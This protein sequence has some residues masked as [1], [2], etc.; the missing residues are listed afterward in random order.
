MCRSFTI[1]E[2]FGTT[3]KRIGGAGAHRRQYHSRPTGENL[4]KP[5]KRCEGVR[6]ERRTS[7]WPPRQKSSNCSKFSKESKII[8]ESLRM[9]N[10]YIKL[11]V[12]RLTDFL[13]VHSRFLQAL[14]RFFSFLFSCPGQLNRWHCQSVT[15]WL[16][17]TVIHLLIKTLV[18]TSRH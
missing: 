5:S 1:A 4:S 8:E 7:V 17:D 6:E 15:Q 18:D 13:A 9:L 16:S 2:K 12:N 3:G 10:V 11:Q 14:R